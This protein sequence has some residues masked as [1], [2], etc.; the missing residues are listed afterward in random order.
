MGQRAS[1][2]VRHRALC[3]IQIADVPISFRPEKVGITVAGHFQEQIALCGQTGLPHPRVV[4][5]DLVCLQTAEVQISE[6]GPES[7]K[8]PSLSRYR[9][10]P[11]AIGHPHLQS[12]S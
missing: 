10:V 11:D 1:R 8:T 4:Q 2:M 12:I 5:H 3:A 9:N 7:A 6:T